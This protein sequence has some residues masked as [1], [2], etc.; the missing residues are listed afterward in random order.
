VAIDTAGDRGRKLAAEVRFEVLGP[1][2]VTESHAAVNIGGPKQRTVLAMLIA[3]AGDPVSVDTIIQA[4][5]GDDAAPSARRIVQTYVATL[6]GAVGDS[7]VKTGNGW[8]LE[9]PRHAI[10]GLAF[11]DL[12]QSAREIAGTNPQRASVALRE[13]LAMWRGHPYADV[14]AHGALSGEI[15][16]LSELRV[17][18]QAARVDADLALGRDAD[19]VGEIEALMAEHP[20][21]ERFRAQQMLALYRAGRQQEALRSYQHMR[22]VLLEELGVDPTPDLQE[23]ERRILDQDDSLGLVP[24]QTIQRRAILVAD[25]GDP[26][27]IGHLPAAE[28][29]DLLTRTTNAV[30][31]AIAREGDGSSITAGTTTYV[32]FDSALA[33]ANVAEMVTRRLDPDGMRFA[34]D[35]GDL[36]LENGRVS[37]PP[38]SRAAVMSAVA[39]K[40]QVLLSAE[41][42]HAIGISGSG[43][44]LRFENL[45]S[46]DLHGV[47]GSLLIY[48]LLIGDMPAVFPDL[49]THRLPPPL[50]GG[51]DRSVP[52][53]ELREALAPGSIGTLYRAFQPSMGREVL[54][55]LIGRGHSSDGEFIRNF[56]A[57]AQR[58]SL[59]DHQNIAPVIDYWRQPDGAFLV[60]RFPRGGLLSD[61]AAPDPGRLVDQIGSALSY[62]HSLG[63]VHG[64]LRPDRIALDEAGNASLLCFPV[65]GVGPAHPDGYERFVAPETTAGAAPTVSSDIYALG[66][67]TRDLGFDDPLIDRAIDDDP[68][69]RPSSVAE[70]LVELNP[71]KA[72]SPADRYTQTR[73]PYKGLSAF[74]EKDALDFF[75][76]SLAIEELCRALTSSR[77][78]AI[79]GPSGIGKSSIARAGLVPALR[80]GRLPGSENWLHTDMF[81]GSHPFLELQRALERV[82]VDLPVTLTEALAAQRP[83]AMQELTGVLPQ[84]SDLVLLIDQFEEL[85]TMVPEPERRAFLDLLATSVETSSVRFV[86]TLRADLLDRP[87]RYSGFGEMFKESTVMLAA[88]SPVELAEAIARPAQGVGVTIAPELVERMVAE[89]HD[90]PGAL[91][92]LQHTL[93]EVFRM[94][95]SDLIGVAAFDEVGGVSGSL[96]RQAESLFGDLDDR[97]RETIKQVFLR[98]VTI[99]PERAPTRR[100]LRVTEL[101][102]LEAQGPIEAFARQRMLVFDNDPETR[103]PTVEVAHEALL[104]HWPRLSAW[105]DATREDLTLLRRLEEARLDWEASGRDPAYVLTGGRLA[106]H[107]AWT[108]SSSLT[109]GAGQREYLAASRAQDERL[110]A[111]ARR[112]RGLVMGG[113]AAAAA[114]ALVFALNASENATRAESEALAANAAVAL[115]TDPELAVL[116]AT[117]AVRHHAG[118]AAVSALHRGLQGHRMKMVIPPPAG[119][120]GAQAVINPEGTQI[121]VVGINSSTVQG[122]E[123]GGSQPSWE[124]RLAEEGSVGFRGYSHHWLSEDGERAYVPI[125]GP[126]AED[127]AGIYTLDTASGATID[128][129]PFPCVARVMPAGSQFAVEGAPFAVDWSTLVEGRC[130]GD[131]GAGVLDLDTGEMLFETTHGTSTP[132]TLSIDGRRLALSDCSEELT[133][134]E[135]PTRVFDTDSGE[136]IFEEWQSRASGT[137][138][139]DGRLILIDQDPAYLYEV[140][141]GRRLQTYQDALSRKWFSSDLSMVVSTDVTGAVVIYDTQSGAKLLSLRGHTDGAGNASIDELGRLVVSSGSDAARLWDVRPRG[142]LEPIELEPSED[143]RLYLEALSGEDEWLLVRRGVIR[144]IPPSVPVAHRVDVIS[145]VT[146]EVAWSDE[147]RLAGLGPGDVI[148]VQPVL[149]TGLV[150]PMGVEGSSLIGAPYLFDLRNEQQLAPL[151]GCDWFWSASSGPEPQSP[152]CE[153]VDFRFFEFSTDG[154]RVLGVDWIGAVSIWDTGSGELVRTIDPGMQQTRLPLQGNRWAAGLSEDGELLV[155]PP[156]EIDWQAAAAEGTSPRFVVE[157]LGSGAEVGTFEVDSWVDHTRW[158]PGSDVIVAAHSDLLIVDTQ[159]WRVDTLSRAQGS[160][161]NSLDVSPN[162]QLVAT[163]SFDNFVVVWN[164]EERR[165]VAEIPVSGDVGETLRGVAFVDDQTVVVAPEAGGELLVFTLDRERLINAALDSVTRGFR[166]S[167]CATYEIDPCPGLEE[168]HEGS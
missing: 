71:A 153:S 31:D 77:L 105:I 155:N 113:F 90:R 165:I 25:P 46:H 93:A 4:V 116:L 62:A 63:M 40:G 94:R 86:V 122:W 150:S 164:I 149:G 143:D 66:A 137:L 64:T 84:N 75:G 147:V 72:G 138:S 151:E 26:I 96:A 22:T 57:D 47:E 99:I 20:Y 156:T 129:V 111:R 7:I 11:E 85:F 136:V 80:S 74:H 162:G 89:V 37:G 141:T 101:A 30:R 163:V 144:Q 98:L 61:V 97:E 19:L 88:P 154:S 24:A 82:A 29:E 17:A 70:Y 81:P 158:V 140:D 142:E 23:L 118:T 83:D 109:I 52:G 38:V 134:G 91:P 36:V 108:S 12:Y 41:A 14:E 92:L 32:I 126:S 125:E 87:L 42:Q 157:D 67:L 34:I 112:R 78:L 15:A 21:S 58:L 51:G 115:D 128:F 117:E 79:V 76:R 106:Q 69:R 132:P 120:E 145:L 167:E 50:P 119:S 133:C 43:R 127:G 139:P 13:A 6:R 152:G 148:V 16:R 168:M 130:G 54:I 160:R 48:Q 53:Y 159:T 49:E 166:D 110:K 1:L 124:V 135:G 59:L 10:D 102:D 68:R 56:E 3:H 104:T 100:R 5:W 8:R 114:L 9:V 2:T 95:R 65:A 121:V 18:A 39:H 146:G 131:G 60:Y 35:W 73:N 107:E 55:E 28:R 27:E 33:A 161:I 103:S 44:G 45:G 123:V